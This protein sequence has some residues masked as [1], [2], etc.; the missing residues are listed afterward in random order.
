MTFIDTRSLYGFTE[1]K[2]DAP[3]TVIAVGPAAG[4]VVR[5]FLLSY[6][7]AVPLSL[8]ITSDVILRIM[9][10]LW[11]V[12][13]YLVISSQIATH[14]DVNRGMWVFGA[15]AVATRPATPYSAVLSDPAS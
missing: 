8:A 12:I 11:I 9:D 4:E 3:G 15:V 13:L 1:L 5:C 6:E 14:V 7:T 2:A 10:G